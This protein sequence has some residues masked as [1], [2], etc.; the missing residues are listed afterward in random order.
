MELFCQIEMAKCPR[1]TRL[2][3]T[4]SETAIQLH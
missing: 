1:L 2:A 4:D 3:T